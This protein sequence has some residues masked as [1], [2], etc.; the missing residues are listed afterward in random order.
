M[1]PIYALAALAVMTAQASA[2]SI[3]DGWCEI[4]RA[5]D[6]YHMTLARTFAPP[7]GRGVR[8]NAM[9]IDCET[10]ER[11]E[12]GQPDRPRK[13]FTNYRATTDNDIPADLHA[14]LDLLEAR[15]AG[16]TLLGRDDY[17]V[18]VSQAEV[19]LSGASAFTTMDGVAHIFTIVEFSKNDASGRAWDELAAFTRV[20][21]GANDP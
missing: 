1:K 16:P 17:A 20:A 3:P 5:R 11:A 14:A 12:A 19:T 6:G 13:L 10:M 15:Y 8:V 2:T 18:Y 7:A 21:H 4:I 9:A